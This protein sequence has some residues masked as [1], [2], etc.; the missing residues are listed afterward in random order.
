M[1]VN[2]T[3]I[4][5]VAT[6]SSASSAAAT[7]VQVTGD[8]FMT[9]LVAQLTNQ[10]PL[11]PM[12]SEAFI[13][14][15]SQLEMVSQLDDIKG[16]LASAHSY[17]NPVSTLGRTVYWVEPDGSLASGEVTGLVKYGG[18]FRLQVGDRLLDF[19]QITIIE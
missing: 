4:S 19:A 18:D 17:T 13:S 9:L 3:A 12:D 8:E 6:S 7:G 15:L 16:I 5:S 2:P 1:L 14:Q 10:D 11:S